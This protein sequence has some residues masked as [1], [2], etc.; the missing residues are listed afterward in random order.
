VKKKI[1]RLEFTVTDVRFFSAFTVNGQLNRNL[2]YQLD[3]SEFVP[4][5]RNLY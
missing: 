4:E 1:K 3:S 2:N 5:S